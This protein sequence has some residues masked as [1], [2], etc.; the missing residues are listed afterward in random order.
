[1]CNNIDKWSHNN[2]HNFK[3]NYRVG[4]IICV[5]TM[6]KKGVCGSKKMIGINSKP[7]IIIIFVDFPKW[8]VIGNAY[9][10]PKKI[11]L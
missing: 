11:M 2:N 1:M 8:W 7:H 9:W 5:I 4:R 6:A 10:W 3:T